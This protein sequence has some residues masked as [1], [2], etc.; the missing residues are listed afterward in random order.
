[1]PIPRKPRSPILPAAEPATS[2]LVVDDAHGLSGA[3]LEGFAVGADEYVMKP[4]DPPSLLGR[5]RD[6]PARRV[7]PARPPEPASSA[8]SSRA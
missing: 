3:K 1:M 7:R 8:L 4:F 2:P 5:C 6:A